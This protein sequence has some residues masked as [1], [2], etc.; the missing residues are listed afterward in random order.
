[1]LNARDEDEHS[2]LACNGRAVDRIF[3]RRSPRRAAQ[4]LVV[5][6][7]KITALADYAWADYQSDGKLENLV[8]SHAAFFRSTF[9]PSLAS[10]LR[11]AN[12]PEG[13]PRV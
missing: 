4:D 9:A 6:S 12:D 11:R 1:M 2:R 8:N 3:S 5:E 7:S 13:A 10:A